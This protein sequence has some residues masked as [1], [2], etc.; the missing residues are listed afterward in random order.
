MKNS[1]FK[2]LDA[3][4]QE[5]YG[6]F[7]GREAE[8]TEL[9]N[10]VLSGKLTLLYGLSGTGKSSLVRCGLANR[11]RDRE[12]LPV[13]VRRSN[14]ITQ[15]MAR[16]L[17]DAWLAA[18]QQGAAAG[19]GEVEGAAEANPTRT[20][21]ALRR[22]Q[23]TSE[24][25]T[26]EAFS[27]IDNLELQIEQ[28]YYGVYRPIYFIF[29]QFE[30]LY[31]INPFTETGRETFD[32]AAQERWEE[33]KH[34]FYQVVRHLLD[35]TRVSIRIILIVREEWWARMNVFEHYVPELNQNRM[36]IERM[37]E[38]EIAEVIRGTATFSREQ[39]A[40]RNVYLG[41]EDPAPET[42]NAAEVATVQAIIETVRD[43]RD[44]SL[45]LIDL[46]IYL[47]R[48][49]AT[50]P[51]DVPAIFT[52]ELVANN[53]LDNVIDGFLEGSLRTIEREL[54]ERWATVHFTAEVEAPEERA[55]RTKKKFKDPWE[56]VNFTPENKALM[57]RARSIPLEVLFRLVTDQ[58]TKRATD[59][60]TILNSPFF[61]SRGITP[62]DIRFCLE[63]LAEYK[64]INSYES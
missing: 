61:K 13:Y 5:D 22:K 55:Q 45:D 44:H 12:W 16:S 40:F 1:P 33:E 18:E 57:A 17:Y 47:E 51:P 14:S 3:F 37:G 35:S 48:L 60:E 7:F 43:T 56:S 41:E 28:V 10:R 6:R 38:R 26:W 62:E 39:E 36:R 42:K 54:V 27:A 52:P 53:Q 23:T 9:Y 46:Q 24:L 21:R 11:F 64:I 4:T 15:A 32:P 25:P 50:F 2:G 8:L 58:G 63:K 30:E 20:R 59:E 19:A 49:L 31:T 29:D 34:N